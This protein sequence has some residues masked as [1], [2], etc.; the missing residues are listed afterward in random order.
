MIGTVSALQRQAQWSVSLGLWVS[1]LVALTSSVAVCQSPTAS[2]PAKDVV[3]LTRPGATA[4]LR[5]KGTVEQWRGRTITMSTGGRA[6][7]FDSDRLVALETRWSSGFK[8]AKNL[9][10][11]GKTGSA[12]QLFA[13]AI[14]SEQRIWAKQ[15]IRVELMDAYLLMGKSAA[16]VQEFR[17]ILANDSNTRFMNR[18]PLPWGN[19]HAVVP[20]AGDWMASDDS[21]TRLLG[22]SW[23]LATPNR[24]AAIQVLS[25]LAEDLDPRI[26]DLAIAQLWRTRG[27]ANEKLVRYW[28]KIIEQMDR[29]SRAGALFV[30]AGAQQKTGRV[31][32][33]ILN[34]M[35]VVTLHENQSALVAASLKE[36]AS[37]LE[38]GGVESRKLKRV[39]SEPFL[40]E[41]QDRFP[42]SVWAK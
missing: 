39:S 32:A 4:L 13:K 15:I 30:L 33:A 14:Q 11:E 26:R 19:W 41:L 20:D 24:E 3:V 8:R 10:V 7:E 5:R 40:A 42:E 38:A 22:A 35:K 9:K 27:R 18:M 6:R 31:D 34:L 23:S 2:D 29:E 16:S 37:V 12:V 25:D 21:A 28:E 1:A 36:I 17:K